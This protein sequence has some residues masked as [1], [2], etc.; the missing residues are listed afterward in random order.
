MFYVISAKRSVAA[1][2]EAFVNFFNVIAP[3]PVPENNY[4]TSFPSK[5]YGFKKMY[6]ERTIAA[7][8]NRSL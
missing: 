1:I 8:H 4:N 7:S 2:L 5:T 3:I 6:R